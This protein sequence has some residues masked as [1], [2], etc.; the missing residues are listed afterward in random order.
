MC[1]SRR[2]VSNE[3]LFTNI[4]IGAAENELC[5]IFP[6]S[7]YRSPR[8]KPQTIALSGCFEFFSKHV[9]FYKLLLTLLQTA[10]EARTE[11]GS[12]PLT[13]QNREQPRMDLSMFGRAT[14]A[15]SFRSGLRSRGAR[16]RSAGRAARPG[17]S[18][19]WGR[20]GAKFFTPELERIFLT[21]TFF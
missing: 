2:E 19:R 16:G 17:H 9:F 3:Y 12:K 11:N 15:R 13:V 10:K 6:L 1:R 5:K 14:S 20:S 7:V 4:G 8:Y 21:L 18:V